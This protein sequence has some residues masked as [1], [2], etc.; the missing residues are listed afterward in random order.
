MLINRKKNY[1]LNKIKKIQIDKKLKLILKI[2]KIKI[3]F[4]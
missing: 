1:L 3:N 2:L 4:I